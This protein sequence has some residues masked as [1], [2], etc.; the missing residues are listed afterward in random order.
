MTK[1]ESVALSSA[2]VLQPYADEFFLSSY[3][4]KFEQ[5]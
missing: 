3:N 5:P 4:G 1:Y 2:N